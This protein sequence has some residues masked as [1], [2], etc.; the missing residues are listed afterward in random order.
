MQM[1]F[2]RTDVTEKREYMAYCENCGAPLG[3]GVRFCGMCGAP[4]NMGAEAKKYC[5]N[6][7]AELEPGAVRSWSR[8]RSS[9]QSAATRQCR[10]LGQI[11]I[12][13][14]GRIQYQIQSIS[15]P[16]NRG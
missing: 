12:R 13:L 1:Q 9:A 7:H 16:G 3:E 14:R 11:Q 10:R 15:H 8:E 4:V 5:S 2:L 6:C